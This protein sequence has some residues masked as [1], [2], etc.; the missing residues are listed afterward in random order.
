MKNKSLFKDKK[1]VSWGLRVTLLV[2]GLS[3]L[4]VVVGK[5]SMPMEASLDS[6]IN[7]QIALESLS[8][9]SPE[10][11]VHLEPLAALNQFPAL[12]PTINEESIESLPLIEGLPLEESGLMVFAPDEDEE[13]SDEASA[14]SDDGSIEVVVEDG[15]NLSVIFS[16]L[17]LPY[18]EVHRVISLGEEVRPLNNLKP[19]Q[20]LRFELSS[21]NKLA[22][23]IVPISKTKQ[24]RIEQD[25]KGDLQART[26]ELAVTT[27]IAYAEGVIQSSLYASAKAAGLSP[28]LIMTLA[29]IFGWQIDFINDVREG[30][31]FRVAYEIHL[32][33]GKQ[34][35]I[36]NVLVAEF[37]NRG[38]TWQAL[39]YE[40]PNGEVGYY[41]PDGQNLQ[42][43]F[44]RYPVEFTRISSHFSLA[45][46]HPIHGVVRPHWGVDLAA[47]IGTPVLAA[48]D[49]RVQSIGW[50]NGYGKVIFLQHDG[51]YTTVYGHLSRFNAN[52]K[53]GSRVKKGD[54]IGY[55]GMTGDATG[56]H[57]HYEFRINGVPK[58][59]LTVKLP[60]SNPIPAAHR[61]E[62][63]AYAESL[64]ADFNSLRQKHLLA[65]STDMSS[66][67]ENMP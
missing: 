25:E 19:G 62:Y 20:S 29:E 50:R 59:P 66:A 64:L 63:L 4:G 38:K 15:D 36:G 26:V 27:E 23:L 8:V 45:R 14:T 2:T 39:R 52:L 24:L 55:V 65:R 22:S 7:D 1:H 53:R 17:G 54:I 47:P 30:D 13:A 11:G 21:D 44:L 32:I 3:S 34:V 48:G 5:V 41:T 16:R 60:E 49:G 10:E 67:I 33:D 57:L 61:K 37:T 12:L 9:N 6:S 46:K 51:G 18:S 35:G 42:R 58:D 56:P 31:Q 43:G 40:L 28:R